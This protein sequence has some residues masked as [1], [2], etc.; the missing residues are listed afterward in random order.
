MTA[1]DTTNADAPQARDD[2]NTVAK[3]L[4]LIAV[5]L[6]ISA[7]VTRLVAL[8]ARFGHTPI[9]LAAAQSLTDLTVQGAL[10]MGLPLLLAGTGYFVSTRK[11][12]AFK[13]SRAVRLVIIGAEIVGTIIL[14]TFLAWL[15]PGFPGSTISFV[16]SGVIAFWLTRRAYRSL[17]TLRDLVPVIVV[18]AIAQSVALGISGFVGATS[19]EFSFLP[20]A[21]V[22]DGRYV[23]VASTSDNLLYLTPCSGGS[24][25][26]AVRTD[27]VRRVI[28]RPTEDSPSLAN[29]IQEGRSVSYGYPD[30]C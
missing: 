6:P 18:S 30:R 26:F 25:L 7:F 4:A 16:A 15:L 21:G 29:V 9:T 8:Y 28:F 14:V 23:E 13:F 10:I 17:M 5:I 3:A 27:E 24:A 1:A 11:P 12:I 22:T 20:D 19:G 2:L